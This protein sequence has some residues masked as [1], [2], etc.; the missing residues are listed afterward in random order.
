MALAPVIV[1]TAISADC[2][3]VTI[4][5]NTGNYNVS[6]NPTGYGSPNEARANLYLKLIVTLKK[7]TGDELISVPAYNENTASSWTITITEDGYYEVYSFLCKAWSAL[8]TYAVGYIAY[9]VATDTFYVSLQA[10]NTNNAVGDTPWWTPCKSTAAQ[11]KTAIALSQPNTYSDV[12]EY[13]ELCNGVICRSKAAAQAFSSN[14]TGACG[15][16]DKFREI[17]FMIKTARINQSDAAYSRA[18]VI[19]EQLQ[20]SCQCIDKE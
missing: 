17:D 18:Q 6:T 12:D 13:I 1:K 3:T 5:D 15:C 2:S 7:S 11:Y 10:A 9:D 14:P 16:G 4:T 19:V 20:Q 8:I